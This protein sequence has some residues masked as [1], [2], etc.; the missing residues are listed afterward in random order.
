MASP[1]IWG[2]NHSTGAHHTS[3]V[4][5]RG[6]HHISGTQWARTQLELLMLSPCRGDGRLQ[7]AGLGLSRFEYCSKT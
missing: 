7:L 4:S 5:C 2:C 1:L 3:T 6:R